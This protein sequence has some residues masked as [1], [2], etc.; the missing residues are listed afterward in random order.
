MSNRPADFDQY[1]EE[2]DQRLA[3]TDPAPELTHVPLRSNE[4]CDV[5][6]LRIT[7]PG[8]YR[9]FG[10]FTVP[11]GDGPH[12]ALLLTPSYGSVKAIPYYNDRKRYITLQIIHRG[13]RL[14]DEPW[15]AEFPG[16]LTERID[17]PEN[18]IY[19]DVAA[20]C[21]RGAEFLLSRPEIDPNRV[22]VWGDDLAVLVA[23]R[24]PGFTA[25]IA[26]GL[27]FNQ[28]LER[29]ARTEAYPLEEINEYLRTFPDNAEAVGASLSYLDPIHHAPQFTGTTLLSV[30]ED[31]PADLIEAFGGPVETYQLANLGGTD[32]DAIDAWIA[33]RMG[34]PAMSRFIREFDREEPAT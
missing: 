5:Y 25:L 28:T 24:R 7:S 10:Y 6:E 12:P 17:D 11:R 1:W 29:C 26:G 22:A 33:A 14:A 19:R 2:V 31:P 9:I 32:N 16:Q 15:A 18:Y 4:H 27:T 13:Q 34:K 23:A 30:G 8:P 3:V 20:D 21:I